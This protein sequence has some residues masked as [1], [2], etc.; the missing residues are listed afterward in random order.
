VWFLYI[1]MFVIKMQSDYICDR[2]NTAIRIMEKK[3]MYQNT[4]VF[5]LFR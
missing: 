1:Y 3:Y 5:T 2:R 4:S